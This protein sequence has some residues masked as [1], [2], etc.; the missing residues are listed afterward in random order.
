MKSII[1]FIRMTF[2]G[3]ILFL[4][5]IIVI[6][7][8]VG[9][10]LVIVDNIISPMA[11]HL[12][13]IIGNAPP[14]VLAGVIL[15]LICFFAGI[16]AR[17]VVA[18]RFVRRLETSFL[19]NLPGYEF[20]KG[21]GEGFLGVES[22]HT[23][24]VVLA[25]VEESWQFGFLME[26]ID[27]GH[28]AVFLP[29]APSPTSGSVYFLTEDRIRPIE[30]PAGSAMKCLKQLGTGANDLLRGQLSAPG[31]GSPPESRGRGEISIAT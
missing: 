23:H 21:I 22:K 9:K 24:E 11:A 28:V 19:S 7:A 25:W 13:S 27:D 16:F 14:K 5:P 3:G 4:V 8:V 15:V 6:V 26:R 12:P 20:M 30:L 18:G 17:T 29:G 10:A 31:T 2:V 1:R